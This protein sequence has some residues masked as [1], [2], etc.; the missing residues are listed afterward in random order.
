MAL[1]ILVVGGCRPGRPRPPL[2]ATLPSADELLARVAARRHVLTSVRGLAR[3]SYERGEERGGS[4]HAVVVEAPDRF[5]L[6][7]LSPLGAL[8][9]VTCDGAELAVWVRRESRIYRGP[10]SA[11]SVAS[12]T[13]LPVA[14]GDV[15]SVLLGLP[16]ERRVTARPLVTRD[17][18]LHLI[19]LHAT[20]DGGWQDILFAPDSLL[21]V[22]SETTLDA[23]RILHVGFADYRTIGGVELPLDVAMRLVPEGGSVRV[24]YESPTIGAAP[25]GDLFIFPPRPGAEEVRLEHYATGEEP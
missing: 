3:V 16:P 8:A 12:Y 6:E 7:V 23:G 15:A 9:V 10:A 5:R 18:E 13:G 2:P 4:R 17:E 22:A 20:I 11:A 21:P 25:G 24:R 19:R 14:V 1:G